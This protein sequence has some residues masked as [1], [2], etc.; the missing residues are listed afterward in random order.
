[1]AA[2][3]N[4]KKELE[5]LQQILK[6][7]IFWKY[8]SSVSKPYA[9]NYLSLGRNYLK[10]IGIIEFTEKEKEYLISLNNKSDIDKFLNN[11]YKI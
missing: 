3:S 10:K 4:N 7:D 1:M 2:V 5:I 6:S 11:K 9:S 8:V